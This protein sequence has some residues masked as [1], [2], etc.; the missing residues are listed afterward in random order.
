L[1]HNWRRLG[2]ATRK[3]QSA[4]RHERAGKSANP[5]TPATPAPMTITRR[6]LLLGGGAALVASRARAQQIPLGAPRLAPVGLPT[7]RHDTALSQGLAFLWVPTQGL[8]NLEM[9]SDR[10]STYHGTSAGPGPF[11]KQLTCTPDCP[12]WS[13]SPVTT[14]NGAGTG[15]FSLATLVQA[16]STA[17]GFVLTQQNSS[18][19]ANIALNFNSDYHGNLT[20]G[21]VTFGVWDGASN[22][23]GAATVVNLFFGNPYL[24][25]LGVRSGGAT[26]T[27]NIYVDGVNRTDTS[28]ATGSLDVRFGT[29]GIG[30]AFNSINSGT[31]G[32]NMPTVAAMMWNRAL[33]LQE[34]ASFRAVFFPQFLA[35]LLAWPIDLL[36]AISKPP[37]PPDPAIFAAPF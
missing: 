34:I 5:A 27:C 21:Q 37:R 24:A 2:L 26:G 35:Q 29:V 25:I 9:V 30:D 7:V 3:R 11:G 23:A 10:L 19:G 15:D 36:A 28:A 20:S 31:G 8:Q 1:A 4:D 18:T 13:F 33:S 14:S 16:S 12:I 6:T 17:N 22:L 32:A